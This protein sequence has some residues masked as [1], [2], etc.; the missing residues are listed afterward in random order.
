MELD[1]YIGILA[2]YWYFGIL[3]LDNC[4]GILALY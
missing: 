3:V 1:N 2:W 4:M